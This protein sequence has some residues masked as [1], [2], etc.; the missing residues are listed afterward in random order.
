M[1][2][3]PI[4][5][6]PLPHFDILRML[7]L[8][9]RYNH[10]YPQGPSFAAVMSYYRVGRVVPQAGDD[11]GLPALYMPDEVVLRE[12]DAHLAAINWETR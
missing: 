3:D 9:H 7:T 2:G 6:L 10:A 5:R 11:S 1:P 8:A 4:T 12:Q